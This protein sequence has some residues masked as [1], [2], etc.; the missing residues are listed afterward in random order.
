LI[1][2]L[3]SGCSKLFQKERYIVAISPD[4]PPMEMVN[5]DKNIVG[6]DVDVIEQIAQRADLNIKI[7]PVLRSNLLRGLIDETY[8]I[9]ISSLSATQVRNS[10]ENYGIESSH[11]YFEIGDVLVLSEDF[12]EYRDL[13][14]LEGK[15]VG[16]KRASSSI[17]VFAHAEGIDVKVYDSADNAFEEMASNKI[18]AVCIDI[19]T[20]AQFVLL[21][22][23]YKRI[24]KIHPQPI[25]VEKYV[26]A[27]KKDNSSLLNRLNSGLEKMKKDGTLNELIDKWFF[28]K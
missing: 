1:F 10:A 20:A 24:F 8:D 3:V 23:E 18:H 13:N 11:P 14:D 5:E 17:E 26:I 28:S 2:I 6:F 4:T 27:V 15:A 25:T 12:G 7:I 22:E 16:V 9:A 19:P 21:N